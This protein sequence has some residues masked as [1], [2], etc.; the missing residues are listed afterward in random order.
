MKKSAP[1]VF[2]DC[3]RCDIDYIKTEI[4]FMNYVWDRKEADVHILITI[5]RTGSGGREYTFAFIG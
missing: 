2:I 4:T 5:Q 3:N 1:K